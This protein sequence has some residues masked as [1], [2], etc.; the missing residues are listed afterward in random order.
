M[1]NLILAIFT[2]GALLS[3]SKVVENNIDKGTKKIERPN[4]VI[5]TGQICG[6]C[7]GEDTL[8]ITMETIHFKTS[9]CGSDIIEDILNTKTNEWNTLVSNLDLEAFSN[10]NSNTC[11]VC[12]DGCDKW[13]II[14]EGDY[15]HRIS[16][17]PLNT[18][19]VAPVQEF[20]AVL[21]SI[22]HMHEVTQIGID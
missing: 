19:V 15:Y 4:L 13:I 17:S 2:F 3:C 9:K 7:S 10:I 16:Y 12:A 14:E 11:N 18:N 1:K 22:R 21:D 6:W 20:V 5:K 8:A